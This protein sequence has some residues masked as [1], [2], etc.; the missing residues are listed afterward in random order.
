MCMCTAVCVMCVF[1]SVA[2]G[3]PRR[4]KLPRWVK[5]AKRRTQLERRQ[6]A[7]FTPKTDRI[8]MTRDQPHTEPYPFHLLHHTVSYCIILHRLYSPLRKVREATGAIFRNLPS[9]PM[10]YA[11]ELY[12]SALQRGTS[13]RVYKY[14]DHALR[15]HPTT[16]TDAR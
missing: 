6:G 16:I 9:G 14:E 13:H 8:N 12:F 5:S 7:N 4:W 15:F 2:V 10:S 11:F 1:V 3:G